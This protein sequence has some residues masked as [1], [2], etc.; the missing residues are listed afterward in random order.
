MAALEDHDVHQ[1]VPLPCLGMFLAAGSTHVHLISLIT[2]ELV[3]TFKTEPMQQRSLQSSSIGSQSSQA[4]PCGVKSF[5]LCYTAA[6]SGDC[7]LQT[8]VPQEDGD[9]ICLDGSVQSTRTGWC[10][11]DTA[12]TTNTHVPN[13]GKWNVLADGSIVGVRQRPR[14]GNGVGAEGR[15]GGDGLRHRSPRKE[16]VRNMFG[17]WELWTVSHGHRARPD[18]TRPLFEEAENYGHLF[19]SELG[20]LVDVGQRSIAFGFGNV[21]KVITVG[22]R[23]RFETNWDR[24][25]PDHLANVG[26]RRRKT[27]S[28]L[29]PTA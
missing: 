16:H 15:P 19:V 17:R 29:R 7:V 3:H 13:P 4:T 26:S 5:T 25:G 8:Y 14:L 6:E 18:E 12:K 24:K 10:S 9:L 21:V 2:R 27:P 22:S 20:P 11:W 23:E 28:S 1:V